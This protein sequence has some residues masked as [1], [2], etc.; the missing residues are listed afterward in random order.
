M[1][2]K[3][4]DS[5]QHLF[6]PNRFSYGW[7]KD[8]PA[9]QGMFALEEYRNAAAGLPVEGTIF[10]EVT[11]TNDLLDLVAA[12]PGQRSRLLEDNAKNIYDL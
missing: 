11:V 2:N 5:H 3:M 10:M 1:P 7:A 6:D 8:F 12:T 4:I 9:L